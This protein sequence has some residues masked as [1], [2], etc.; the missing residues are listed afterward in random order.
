MR[1]DLWARGLLALLTLVTLAGVVLTLQSLERTRKLQLRTLAALRKLEA[2][3]AAAAAGAGTS[4][5]AL[6]N[7][8]YFVRGAAPAG[9]LRECIASE[10]P[11]LNPLISN[12]ATAS[13]LYALCMSTL[14]ERDWARPD[15]EF[16]PLM[17]ARWEIS[18]DRLA[19]HIHLRRGIMWNDYTDPVT[20]RHVPAK[21]VT[22]EDFRFFVEVLRDV[23]VNCAPLRSYYQDL[24]DLEVVNSHEFVVRW[25]RPFYGSLTATLGMSP[26]PRHYF[27]AY[28]GP[29]DGKRFNDDHRR[30]AFIVGCGPYRLER[31]E[32]SRRI[33]LR[34]NDA[35]FGIPFGIAPAL[36]SRI[37]DLIQLPN[38]RFQA[39]AARRLDQL[40]LTADQWVRQRDAEIFTSGAFRRFKSPALMYS[41]IGWNQ[42]S[43]LFRDRRVRQA[44]TMLVD[45]ERIIRDIMHGLAIPVK[46]PFPPASRYSDPKLAPWPYDPERAKRL[47]A[48]AG[49]RDTDGDGILDKDGRK[50]SFTMLQVANHPTQTRMFP[51]L[52]ESFGAAGIEMKIQSLEWSVYL[53]RLENRGYEACSLGWTSS[54]DPDPYQVWHSQGIAPPGSNHVG[55]AN[56]ELDKL[57]E[58]LRATFDM[59][60]RIAIARRI[61]AVIH[62]DQPY[63]F[64]YAPYALTAVSERFD[65]VRLFP[66]GLEPLIYVQRPAAP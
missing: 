22:A 62:A 11:N 44:L 65:N 10:P 37:F 30:N 18:P 36:E 61:E 51:L 1:R 29:F 43:P 39:L 48:E 23:R 16:K 52:K 59:A 38:T 55:Y 21:E 46:G 40:N 32:R 53:E 41:Y 4:G 56:A 28:P 13:A 54:F 19:Y 35:Y 58:E 60:R 49:W 63:T 42:K 8:E 26:L 7:A 25:K 20:G 12:E 5:E 24:D 50:F 64:L 2:H 15:G 66:G 33:V 34:R 47:L 3:P 45:R 6:A 31:W 27:H 9:R 14:A 57:I 17:A